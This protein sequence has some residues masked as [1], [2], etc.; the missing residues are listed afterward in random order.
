MNDLKMFVHYREL[1]CRWAML[2]Y[3]AITKGDEELARDCAR[4]AAT[5]ARVAIIA[6]GA[7]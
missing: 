3:E 2:A 6:R 7:A 1:A 5:Y 4:A